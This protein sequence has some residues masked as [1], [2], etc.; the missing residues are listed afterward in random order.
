MNWN[1]TMSSVSSSLT[2][3]QTEGSA[4][5]VT[6]E[7]R[8][9][10]TTDSTTTPWHAT[11]CGSLNAAA[12]STVDGGICLPGE[13]I[14]RSNV[15]TSTVIPVAQ[16]AVFIHPWA[17]LLLAFPVMTVFGNVLVCLSVYRERSLRTA[18]NFFIVS[19]AV[20]DIMVAILVMPLAVY[21]EVGAQMHP[22]NTVPSFNY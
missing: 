11:P 8:N 20:A 6:D 1:T 18:T 17:L 19:L 15:S 14:N 9:M 3:V 16:C 7:Y 5:F 22:R 4:T 12:N 2:A 13:G 10:S 21:V